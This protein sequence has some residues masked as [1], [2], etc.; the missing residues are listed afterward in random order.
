MVYDYSPILSD[1]ILFYA[2]SSRDQHKPGNLSTSRTF[3]FAV[4][5]AKF[6]FDNAVHSARNGKSHVLMF[7]AASHH[8]IPS[9]QSKQLPHR[10]SCCDG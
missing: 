2:T 1:G 6:E 7:C 5:P 9:Q 8:D 3:K 4:E 10:C